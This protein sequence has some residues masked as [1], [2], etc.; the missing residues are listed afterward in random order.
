LAKR[1][2][3]GPKVFLCFVL[4]A[5]DSPRQNGAVPRCLF[6]HPSPFPLLYRSMG[7]FQLAPSP[8][9]KETIINSCFIPLQEPA[10]SQ[11]P[12]FPP[13]WRGPSLRCGDGAALPAA[14]ALNR[15]DR[16]FRQ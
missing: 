9:L 6:D 7:Q 5:L 2:V 14:A 3:S 16:K 4:K 11:Q 1:E 10:P 12:T 13:Q 8:V 15:S